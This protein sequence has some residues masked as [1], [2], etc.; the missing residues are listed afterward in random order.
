MVDAQQPSALLQHMAT[1]V[2]GAKTP[3][4]GPLAVIRCSG[5]LPQGV[6]DSA[7]TWQH[8]CAGRHHTPKA[9]SSAIKLFS[10]PTS[11]YFLVKILLLRP[12]SFLLALGSLSPF[13][14]IFQPPGYVA[15]SQRLP[16]STH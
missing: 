1:L 11:V 6:A 10:K 5:W 7:A 9:E 13:H 4:N 2:E 8:I 3:L 15:V 12:F 16:T 14:S